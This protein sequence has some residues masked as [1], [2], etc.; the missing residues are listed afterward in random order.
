MTR[1]DLVIGGWGSS[2]VLANM[3]V[4]ERAGHALHRRRRVKPAHYHQQATSG[5]SA[6]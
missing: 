2:Q 6:R 1:I 5:P 3:A 4:A